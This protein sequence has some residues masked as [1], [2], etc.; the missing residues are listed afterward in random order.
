MVERGTVDQRAVPALGGNEVVVVEPFGWMRNPGGTEPYGRRSCNRTISD[1]Q[2]SRPW[3]P[4]GVED[5]AFSKACCQVGRPPS[6]P[7]LTKWSLPRLASSASP[8]F[9]ALA[10]R[11]RLRSSSL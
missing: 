5:F 1:G 11:R 4:L 3:P 9:L 7:M 2:C 6:L 8:P 10:I